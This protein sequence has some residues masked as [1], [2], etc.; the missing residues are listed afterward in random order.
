MRKRTKYI[1][2]IILTF[3]V[4]T[5]ISNNYVLAVSECSYLDG[6]FVVEYDS[7][8]DKLVYRTQEDLT[9]GNNRNNVCYTFQ[10]HEVKGVLGE[11]F[12]N[13]EE[14]DQTQWGLV[15]SRHNMKCLPI[16]Y[17][18]MKILND[19]PYTIHY[20]IYPKS[21]SKK[22]TTELKPDNSSTNGE[23]I[24]SCTISQMQT[25]QQ[26]YSDEISK[27]ENNIAIYKKEIEEIKNGN[28]NTYA[29]LASTYKNKI[30]QNIIN[31]ESNL[32][33][34]QKLC[35]Y[36]TSYDDIMS[37]LISSLTTSSNSFWEYFDSIVKDSTNVTNNQVITNLTENAK[38]SNSDSIQK[39]SDNLTKVYTN[40][41]EQYK[42]T[43]DECQGILTDEMIDI[44][45]RI[46]KYIRIAAPIL[47]IVFGIMDFGKAVLSDE[48][49]E[50]K[51]ATSKFMKRAIIVV[52]IFFVPLIVQLLI[53]AFNSVSDKSITDLINCGIK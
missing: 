10:V 25:L 4:S 24:S 42:T 5:F 26:V 23:K 43:V 30:N 21:N 36:G 50:L 53:D 9:C 49:E 11:I 52:V 31:A 27:F 29:N 8:N 39:V 32:A 20:D 48:K 37:K 13:Q 44:L 34:Y 1:L 6:K 19:I 46:I 22:S 33:K 41:L 45:N 12:G 15:D 28:D 51:K 38:L 47:L 17:T 7:T 2:F 14:L 40:F 3:V 35:D 18:E 16:Y